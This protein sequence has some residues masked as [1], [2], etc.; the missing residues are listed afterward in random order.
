MRSLLIGVSLGLLLAPALP[1][2]G[3]GH[4]PPEPVDPRPADP[5]DVPPG[6]P[7]PPNTGPGD[8]RGPASPGRPGPGSGGPQVGPGTGGG[9]NPGPSGPTTPLPGGG[10]DLAGWHLWWEINQRSFLDLKLAI[11]SQGTVTGGDDFFLG[12][13]QRSLPGSLRPDPQVLARTALPALLA[14]IERETQPEVLSGL[15]M[16]LAKMGELPPPADGRGA[17][18]VL[19]GFLD[20]PNQQIAE[21]AALALGVLG[22]RSSLPRLAAL[23]SGEGAAGSRAPSTRSPST[24]SSART[25]AFAAYGLGLAAA[26]SDLPD[27]RRYAV[28]RL[29]RAFELG[30]SAGS[31]VGVACAYALALI[32]LEPNPEHLAPR[33]EPLPPAAS[34]EALVRWTLAQLA[35]RRL[36]NDLRAHLPRTAAALVDPDG[37]RAALD[38]PLRAEVIEALCATLEAS[39]RSDPELRQGAILALGRVAHAGPEGPDPRA[40]ALLVAMAREGDGI[41][42]GLAL[43]ALAQV[44]SRPGPPG[45]GA[46]TGAAEVQGLLLE[47]LTRG[48]SRE[49]PFAALALGVQGHYLLGRG[50]PLADST[51]AALRAALEDERSP[52]DVGAY[53][54]AVGLRRDPAA[55]PL[56]AAKLVRTADSRARGHLALALGLI[57]ERSYAAL[58][59]RELEGEVYRPESSGRMA[60]GLALLGD[61]DL[62]PVLVERMRTTT[63]SSMRAVHAWTLGF[64]GDGRAV[65]PILELLEDA[66][67]PV[68]QRGIAALALGFAVEPRERP[69]NTALARDAHYPRAPSTLTGA[70]SG[71]GGGVLDI[72]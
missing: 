16:A 66:G 65:A 60:M 40:R 20:S 50:L 52:L 57:G 64:V 38:D 63:S 18:A 29:T 22:R 30:D 26:A 68:L 4:E 54:L 31:D 35:D 23:L 7:V 43:M 14:R 62:V 8:T 48:R 5:P 42:R 28:Q 2:H 6:R 47:I 9:A 53:A 10:E 46:M 33:S 25:R 21:T 19:V 12:H 49:R 69:W 70:P 58:L 61:K 13:G 27:A 1:G 39:R 67:T 59:Q 11:W 71:E 44:G 36:R 51:G 41:S 32:E 37:G 45:P 55:A 34:R 3:G 56:V 24:R 17:E 15:L 72:R